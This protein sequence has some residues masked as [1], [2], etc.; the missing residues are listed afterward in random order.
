MSNAS[1][2]WGC[3]YEDKALQEY[4]HKCMTKHSNFELTQ[5]GC[6]IDEGKPFIGASPDGCTKC[7]CCGNGLVEVKCTYCF[8]E[9]L[10]DEEKSNFCMVK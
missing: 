9:G 10:P 6:V 4:E 8:K 3:E 5:S 7:T 1:Y 2:R